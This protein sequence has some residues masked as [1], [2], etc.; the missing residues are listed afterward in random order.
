MDMDTEKFLIESFIGEL[1]NSF[2]LNLD[3]KPTMDRECTSNS[4]KKLRMVIVGMSHARNL[5]E[6]LEGMGATVLY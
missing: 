4:P 5:A 3:P 1:N 2:P 6:A